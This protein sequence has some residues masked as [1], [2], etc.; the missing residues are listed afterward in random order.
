MQE[1]KE[2][3]VRS[4]NWEDPLEE[5][6][7][8]HC[9]IL[10]WRIP[11]DR[12]ASWRATVHRITKSWIW[13]KQL[14]CMHTTFSSKESKRNFFRQISQQQ[15][16]SHHGASVSRGQI[17]LQEAQRS[18][19][20]EQSPRWRKPLSSMLLFSAEM[21]FPFIIFGPVSFPIRDH[22]C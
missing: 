22:S 9:S 10:V 21:Q 5:S 1:S 4:L 8:T 16:L 13:L 11:L 14:A 19:R 3:W 2:M 15:K 17:S 20:D 6:I 7:A 18:S 12:G